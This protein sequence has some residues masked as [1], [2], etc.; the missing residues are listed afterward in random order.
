MVALRE[1]VTQ[2]YRITPIIKRQQD[3]FVIIVPSAALAGTLRLESRQIM[4]QC[5]LQQRLLV[6]IGQ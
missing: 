2:R 3:N 5:G 6:R 4:K 1:Y